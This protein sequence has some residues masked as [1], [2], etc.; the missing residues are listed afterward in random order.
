MGS[1][2]AC[3]SVVYRAWRLEGRAENLRFVC[4]RLSASV[5]IKVTESHAKVDTGLEEPA[6]ERWHMK[7]RAAILSVVAVV[8][9]K[10]R[11]EAERGQSVATGARVRWSH[12]ELKFQVHKKLDRNPVLEGIIVGTPTSDVCACQHWTHLHKPRM[13]CCIYLL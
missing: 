1:T 6:L 11:S 13:S 9:N 12:N 4:E 3:S 2:S 5:R 7:P 8:Y 10:Q